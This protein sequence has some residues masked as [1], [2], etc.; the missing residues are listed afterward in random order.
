MS[1]NNMRP[2]HPG[3]ILREEYLS[4]L[5]LSAQEFS[6]KE[7][8]GHLKGEM[9]SAKDATEYLGISISTFRRYVQSRKIVPAKV[10][11]RSQLYSTTD[12]RRLKKAI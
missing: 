3:E 8:F 9:F 12:L 11:G 2:I 1:K 4:P 6:H 10:I 7:V 5:G